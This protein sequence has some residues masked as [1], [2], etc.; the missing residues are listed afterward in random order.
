MFGGQFGAFRS[1]DRHFFREDGWLFGELGKVL[2]IR[3]THLA[4]R[5]GRQYLRE[6]S[7]NGADYGIPRMI[8]DE[9]RSIVA[10]SRILDDTEILLALNTDTARP[11]Q[12]SVTI[13]AELH[14][15]GQSMRC[16]YST[17]PTEIGSAIVIVT[18]PDGRHVVDLPVPAAGFAIYL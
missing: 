4:L 10:S 12:V 8:G 15:Q 11:L 17:D 16:L 1:R 9:I 13:D 18:A 14:Q 2:A 7:G 3:H 6:I 5:R